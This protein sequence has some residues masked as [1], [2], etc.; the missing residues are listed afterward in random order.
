MAREKSDSLNV[1]VNVF[2]SD[3]CAYN[4]GEAHTPRR[5]FFIRTF[6]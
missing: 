6:S 2:S 1:L 4:G 3:W 5:V